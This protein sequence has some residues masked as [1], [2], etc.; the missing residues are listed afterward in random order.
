VP[1]VLAINPV[2]F[3][4]RKLYIP[5]W[6]TNYAYLLYVNYV[7]SQN[8]LLDHLLAIILDNG[9]IV[10]S[11]TYLRISWVLQ[12]VVTSIFCW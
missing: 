7:S 2:F 6:I 3:W 10:R 4:N 1:L 9:L 12:L 8:V 5:C 11:V